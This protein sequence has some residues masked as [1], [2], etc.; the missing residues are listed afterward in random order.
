MK[1]GKVVAGILLGASVT[2][3]AAAQPKPEQSIRHRQAVFTLVGWNFGPM[4]QMVRGAV[5]FD[6]TQFAQRA[7]RLAALSEMPLEGFPKGSDKGARTEAKA[8][9]W[10]EWKDFELKM[11][12]FKTEATKLAQVAKAGDEAAMKAQFGKTAGTCKACHD[13]FKE[14]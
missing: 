13:K 6:K 12:N 1:A 3:I 11:G 9:I 2:L 14:D 7:N 4:G 8:N 10:T 5:P